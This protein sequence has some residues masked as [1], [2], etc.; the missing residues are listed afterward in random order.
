MNGVSKLDR[1]ARWM[2]LACVAMLML[3]MRL[4]A[5][6]TPAPAKEGTVI[7]R[8]VAVVNGDLILES[9][10]DEERR[11]AAFEP[12]GDR[13]QFSRDRA[14]ERLIDRTLILQQTRLQPEEG[15]TSAAVKEQLQSLRRDIPACKQYHCETDA[16][17]AKFVAD[18]GFTVAEVERRWQQ[19]MQTLKFVEV[20]FRMG[21]RI[22]PEEIKS[23]YDK[24][25]VPAYSRQQD[26]PPTLESVSD[27]IQEVLL[28]QQVTSLLEDWLKTL[29]AQGTVRIIRPDEVTP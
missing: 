8:V 5:Q 14:V 29:R 6:S 12:Y 1:V 18:Q 19:R 28:E 21:I 15:V 23:Y 13:A 11:F 3:S 4:P 9:D 10:V 16:G 2:R 17:W 24:T 26:T 25:F 20:R 7:D 27:R 22:S